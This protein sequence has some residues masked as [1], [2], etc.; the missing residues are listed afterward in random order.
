MSQACLRACVFL[1]ADMAKPND[2]ER[3]CLELTLRRNISDAKRHLFFLRRER[4][5]VRRR[6]TGSARARLCEYN[7]MNRKTHAP[8]L[9][10]GMCF[11]IGY[12]IKNE[13]E[14]RL[15]V[16]IFLFFV[17][18]YITILLSKSVT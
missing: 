9:L 11:S 7:V 3:L 1:L 16:W 14:V 18:G 10:E 15:L 8:S 5:K 2:S 17:D 6:R 12:L 13:F 4:A